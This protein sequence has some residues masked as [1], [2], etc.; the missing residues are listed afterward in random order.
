MVELKVKPVHMMA[1]Q[2][3]NTPGYAQK[4]TEIRNG[5]LGSRMRVPYAEGFSLELPEH[6]HTIP[7][8]EHRMWLAM[9]GERK[10][11]E[12]ISDLTAAKMVLD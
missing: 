7:V 9:G 1:S 11:L 8:S 2:K 4:T 6:G 10:H 5:T 12:A 3:Y